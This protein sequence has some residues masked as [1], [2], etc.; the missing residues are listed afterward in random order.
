MMYFRSTQAEYESIRLQLDAAWGYPNAET[1]TETAIPLAGTLPSDSSGRV[2]LAVPDEYATYELIA[3][4]LP[5]LIADGVIEEITA[6]QYRDV[7][8]KAPPGRYGT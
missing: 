7:L 2:Y 5:T 8:P 4:L 3:S 1:K 6:Q